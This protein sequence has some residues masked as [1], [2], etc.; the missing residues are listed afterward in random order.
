MI[1]SVIVNVSKKISSLIP[2]TLFM[3]ILTGPMK[4]MKW[5]P[6]SGNLVCALGKYENQKVQQF[7]AEIHDRMVVYD[8]GA[9]NGY[10]TL[11]ASKKNPN[12]CVVAFEPFP[13]NVFT[14]QR[15]IELNKLDNVHIINAA[16]TEF[17]G[18][19]RFE[20]NIEKNI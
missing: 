19:A 1:S 2:H 10:Y 14:L 6:K 13:E 16:V 9:N 17:T 4:G 12:G 18:L 7:L 20:G 3:P 5:L 15:H 11:I 8:I